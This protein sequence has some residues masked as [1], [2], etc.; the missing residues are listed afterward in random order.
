MA[1]T[2]EVG[3]GPLAGPVVAACVSLP[4]HCDPTLFRDSK[5]LSPKRRSS[6]YQTIMDCGAS[7]GV[8]M[9]SHQT[10]DSIN[11][12]QASLL[13]MKLAIFNHGVNGSP[14]DY[15]L[16]DGT[17][18]IPFPVEQLT[19]TKGESKSGSIAA[20][21]IVAKVRR[22]ELMN[23]ADILYPHYGFKR[24][25]G[26]PTKEHREA[27]TKYGPCDIHRMTFK[28]VREFVG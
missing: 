8:G 10:I 15:V 28:G 17:F 22:D 11:I 12:L 27:V 16:V 24:N 26:Y 18:T 3:R 19:L 4:E 5:V 20:A 13:A 2:D 1:G 9:V 6:L 23:N 7:I 14:P 25:R 21:S